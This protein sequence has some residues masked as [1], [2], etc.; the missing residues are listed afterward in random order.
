MRMRVASIYPGWMGAETAKHWAS[1]SALG[2][3]GPRLKEGGWGVTW[4]CMKTDLWGGT[5]LLPEGMAGTK[6]SSMGKLFVCLFV[7]SFVCSRF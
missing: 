7:C 4:S 2:R 3:H 1:H 5:R 6:P